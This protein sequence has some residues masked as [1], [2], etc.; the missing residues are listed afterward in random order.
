VF[1]VLKGVAQVEFRV[2]GRTGI[3]VSEIGYGAWGIGG[4]M[5]QGAVDAES[6]KALHEAAELGVNF[7]DTAFVYGEGHS[8]TLVGRF[9]K[10]WKKPITV[11]TKVPPRN[12]TWPAKPGTPISE[13]FP[14]EHIISS[15]EKS[16]RNLNVGTIDLLQ[17]HV[18]ND[19]WADKD[20]W[21]RAFAKLKEQG[22]VRYFGISI[23][24]HQPSNGLKAAATGLIDTF[25]VIYN[26]FDQTP[27]EE[28]FPFCLKENIGVIARV[29]F[30]EGALTGSITP[31]SV[32]PSGDFRNNYFKGE[33]KAEV[34]RRTSDLR[35]LLGKE[36][37]SL[38]E[39]ALRF[40]LHHPAVS[41]VI[42]GMRSIRNVRSNCS[43]SDGRTLSEGLIGRLRQHAW[44]KN[45]YD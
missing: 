11:A 18:W 37:E 35:G 30:D 17:L 7:I 14:H 28:L 27:E 15:T 42:P 19:D 34:L 10:E 9:L 43:V 33:R 21:K 13:A 2:L 29:P 25:Q 8:E 16:L 1:W 6:M 20:E 38:P 24:D 40:C 26:I 32:F 3:R 22:K 39:L 4:E 12:R 23:N 36:A 45:F 44:S 41:T 5:W 31:E